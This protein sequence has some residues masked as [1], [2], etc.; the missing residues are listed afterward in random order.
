MTREQWQEFRE[1]HEQMEHI[2]L[3]HTADVRAIQAKEH[4]AGFVLPTL[5]PGPDG[6][7]G[8]AQFSP[9]LQA[10]QAGFEDWLRGAALTQNNAVSLDI[11]V[12]AAL[13]SYQGPTAWGPG[14][15]AYMVLESVFMDE[16][17]PK[18]QAFGDSLGRAKGVQI[19]VLARFV[20]VWPGDLELI[21]HEE[22]NR[23]L[24]QQQPY[25]VDLAG[26]ATP[27]WPMAQN[28]LGTGVDAVRLAAALHPAD[29][30]ARAPARG[31]LSAR[32][33]GWMTAVRG[34][35]K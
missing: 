16:Y 15:V 12:P 19:S 7:V 28:S 11:Y 23:A 26:S 8:P 1:T 9:A 29:A 18:L 2:T 27:L 33:D 21:A 4:R 30:A 32:L 31:G 17:Y 34:W 25:Q 24:R 3:P 13:H 20:D 10:M 14:W 5:R 22:L 35:F 6:R